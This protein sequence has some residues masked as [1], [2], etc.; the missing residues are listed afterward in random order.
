MVIVYPSFCTLSLS[1]S[2]NAANYVLLCATCDKEEL[3]DYL[4]RCLCLKFLETD[5]HV[6][7]QNCFKPVETLQEL[8]LL[9]SDALLPLMSHSVVQG[10]IKNLKYV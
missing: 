9:T 10:L 3:E 2:E 6:A 7:P 4:V 1:N 8:E 5:E